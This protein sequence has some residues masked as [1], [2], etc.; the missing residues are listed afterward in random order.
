MKSDRVFEAWLLLSLA[1]AVTILSCCGVAPGQ[2]VDLPADQRLRF[3]NRDG[4][5]VQ[6]SIGLLGVWQNVPAA[7][8][9]LWDSEYGPAVRGG[10]VPSRVREYC[11]RRGIEAHVVTRDVMPWIEWA[12]R[13]RRGAAVAWVGRNGVKKNHMVVVAGISDDGRFGV[14]DGNRP[15][16]I[17]WVERAVFQRSV[18]G[19]CVILDAPPGPGVAK[20]VRWWE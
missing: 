15:A 8:T 4:S 18:G 9:L 7:E 10:A 17:R 14:W 11:R 5:C 13:T 3:A 16:A 20:V 2:A 19:W 1:F 6:C 12:V